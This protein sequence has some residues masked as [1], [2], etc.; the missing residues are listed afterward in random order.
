MKIGLL[1]PGQGSQYAGMGKE[2]YENFPEAKAVFDQAN[3]H[4]GF[5]LKKIIFEGPEEVLR[6]T[7]Y[8]QLAIFVTSLALFRV[9]ILKSEILNLN[10]VAAGHSLG[11]YSAFAAAEVFTL[12]E[13]LDLVKARGQF[14][15]KASE[16]NPGTMVAVIG[17]EKGLLEQICISSKNGSVCEMVNFNSPG[18][19]VI[20]GN[21]EAVNKVVDVA[22]AKGAMKTVMLNVSGPFHSSLM[23]EASLMMENE[24]K[25][26]S[27]S[28]PK[29]PVISNCDAKTAT[30]KDVIKEKLVK[31]INNPV[32]WEDSIGNMIKNGVGTF[33]E[34]GPGRVLSGLLKRIDKTKRSFNIED[35]A[36]LE[37]T[38][39]GLA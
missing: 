16:Q 5:D 10:Y 39:K 17:L 36:S 30:N 18:Q 24:L 37:K 32:Y 15:A 38:I 20:S 22:K 2:M 31:Q 29:F 14:I 12:T 25:K 3:E 23:A 35:Q 21:M 27:F 8:T 6:Q 19:I 13:G 1:F 11:E 28:D 33:I 26:Y 7:Q 4:L 9:F 34:I